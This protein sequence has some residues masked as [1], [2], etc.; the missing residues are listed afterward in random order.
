MAL[1]QV[2]FDA[3]YKN[4]NN[5]DFKLK[6]PCICAECQ[7][8]PKPFMH[9]YEVLKNFITKGR[10]TRE[11]GNSAEDVPIKG[12][13]EGILEAQGALSKEL[14]QLI[15]ND[16]IATFFDMVEKNKI[17]NNRIAQLKNEFLNNGGGA[18]FHERLKVWVIDHEGKSS[19]GFGSR[20]WGR[21][22]S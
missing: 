16:E 21:S 1:I 14:L 7:T 11:C 22:Y 8:S 19:K 4:L 10:T 6:I 17:S 13:T 3:I 12:L 9:D 2:H 5:P 20:F 18:S 15:E